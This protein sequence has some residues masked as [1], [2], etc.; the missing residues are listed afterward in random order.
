MLFF[1]DFVLRFS[2]FNINR[3][4][5]LINLLLPYACNYKANYT[6]LRV[7]GQR[8]NGESNNENILQFPL[9][10]TFLFLY[11]MSVYTQTWTYLKKSSNWTNYSSR[12]Q[13]EIH[14]QSSKK[15]QA[16]TGSNVLW[17]D[18]VTSRPYVTQP[19][20]PLPEAELE[21]SAGKNV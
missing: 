6:W 16:K 10:I 2:L 17:S 1:C 19:Q 15:R 20:Y 13:S 9:N 14:S 5:W 18:T 3:R 4:S 11:C 8:R 21:D 7:M 12:M